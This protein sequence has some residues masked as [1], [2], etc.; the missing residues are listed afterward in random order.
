MRKGIQTIE[1]V[2][3]GN[4]VSLPFESV[5]DDNPVSLQHRAVYVS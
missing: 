4:S 2:L 3:T 5:V 1:G